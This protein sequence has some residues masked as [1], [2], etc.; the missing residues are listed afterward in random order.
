MERIQLYIIFS[1][2]IVVGFFMF[3]SIPGASDLRVYLDENEIIEPGE[4]C[5]T[6]NVEFQCEQG[7]TCEVIEKTYYTTGYCVEE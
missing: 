3:V 1:I 6:P 2:F 4:V 5:K 7:Y